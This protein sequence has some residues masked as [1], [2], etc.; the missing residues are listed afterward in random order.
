LDDI[1]PR[2]KNMPNKVHEAVE[3]AVAGQLAGQNLQVVKEWKLKVIQLYETSLVR[4][5]IMVVGTAGCGKTTIFN[6][7]LKSLT[8]IPG[9]MKYTP[10]ILNPKAVTNA[11]LFGELIKS[12]GEWVPG[13][14]A[15]IWK[16]VNNRANKYTS[17]IICDGPVDAIW[18]ESMNTVLDDNRMLTLANAERIP[19][20]DTTKM[21]FEVENLNNASPA[22]VSRAGIIYVSPEDLSWRP[23]IHTWCEDRFIEK[24]QSHP[25]EKT[26]MTEFT[27]KYMIKTRLM[28]ELAT[29]YVYTM[30]TPEV[31]RTTMLLNLLQAVLQYFTEQGISIDRAL[32]EKTFIYALSWSMGGLFETDDRV[33]FHKEI[34]EKAG[35]PLPPITAQ[36]QISEKE[37]IFDF[38]IDPET[39]NWAY[40]APE[41]WTAPK[42]IIFSQ[43]LIPTSDSTRAE[44]IIHKVSQLP[45]ERSMIREEHGLQHSLLVGSPGTAKTSVF[46]MY[47]DKFDG[48]VRSFKRINFSNAT[49]PSNFQAG[50][51]GELTKH[52]ARV[53]RPNGNKEM[54][55]FMDDYSMPKIN[56]WGDQETLEITRLCIEQRGL[57]SLTPDDAG[58]FHKF[59][60]LK[61]CAA[62]RHP[63]GGR[64]TIPSRIMRHFFSMN[65]PPPST[66]AI[67]NIYG[68]ILDAIITTKRYPGTTGQEIIGM[69]PLLIES[70]IVLWETVSKR[71]LPTPTKFH[72]EFN[73]RDLARV[74]QGIARVAQASEYKVI[75]TTSRLKEKIAPTL[76]MIG[77]WRHE[78]ERTFVDRLIT[79]QDKKIFMDMLGK[80]TKEKYRD[81]C[82]FDD[83]QLMTDLLFADFQR[84]AE[85][86]E[87]GSV[88][89]EAP[90]VYEAC[91][92]LSSIKKRVNERLADYNE[93]F[94][95]KKME[96][97]IFDD[98][99]YH[100]LRTTR[101][102]NSANGNALLVGVGGSGKQSLTK[103]SA[104]IC[105]HKFFQ[106]QLTKSYTE[107]S[108]MEDIKI[109]FEEIAMRNGSV[110]FIITDAEIK[111]EG[112]LELINSLLATGEIPGMLNKDDREMFSLGVKPQLQKDLGKG[113]EPTPSQLAAFF[114]QKIKDQLH[115]VLAFS[116]VGNKF[117]TRASYFPSL[118]SQCAIDWFLPWPKEALVDVSGRFIGQFDIECTPEVKEEL[119]NHMGEC[120]NMVQGV[121]DVYF[122]RMRRN[123]YVTPKSYLS[124]IDLYKTLYKAKWQGIDKD[125]SNIQ[126]GLAKLLEA[127]EGV[128][129]MKKLL[130]AED[131]KLRQATEETNKLIAVLTVENEAAEKKTI[132]VQGTKE[133]CIAKKVSIGLEK[134]EADKDLRAAMPFVEAAEKALSGIKDND[135]SE[136]KAMKR[137]HD[138]CRLILDTVQILF[139]GPLVPVSV[140]EY[141]IQKKPVNFITDSY[142][143]FTA[144]LLQGPLRNQLAFF[145]VED[146]NLINEETI[147]L[148]APYLE[149]KFRDVEQEV[150]QG[151]IA[152]G[153]SSALKGVCEWC[154]AMSDYHKASKIVKPK[155]RLLNQKEGE[156][157]VAESQLES[158]QQELAAVIK[159]KAGLDAMYAEKQSIKEAMQAKANQLKR[160]MDQATKLIDSLADNKIRWTQSSQEFQSQ[161]IRLAGDVAKASAFVS[162]CGPFNAE[163]RNLL[164]TEYFENDLNTRKIPNSDDLKLTQFLVDEQTVGDWNMEGLPTDDLSIQNGIMVTRSS[165]YPLMIDP[166]G[167]AITWIRNRERELE[168]F[169]YIFTL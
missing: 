33:K 126:S 36:K 59:E 104:H 107:K 118:F 53:F 101:T 117:R 163:F 95:A 166:Q 16:R 123:V 40:W 140:K 105:K 91:T 1:F 89:A 169:G 136:L 121:R 7:L 55:V 17:W 72:Y 54:L 58:V 92:S 8:A 52:Q 20:S 27:E 116:P 50:I 69:K 10:T 60:Q 122:E 134:E 82:G 4:H 76:F 57:Y 84:D 110:S 18:I 85:I 37:S 75:T 141:A 125:Q 152:K 81:A 100:L 22:T 156:L 128:G 102:I 137:P 65:M 86:D 45:L 77:L 133:A 39:K 74:F 148:L 150:F 135:I 70:T 61:Y 32:Y 21:T 29:K 30:Q 87:Y 165:R 5:G 94:P 96:L 13:I 154:R 42:K 145:G 138:I 31:V 162:Y 146:K 38:Y 80:V 139:L 46:I 149:L 131:V 48:D 3:K 28:R 112:F 64:N 168:Q 78:A 66:R 67:Q 41:V 159:K 143:E 157:R 114:L 99:L 142:E 113:V 124:F 49:R 73:I 119:V 161:K 106:I 164:S 97:V 98:A 132:E 83:D 93:R 35:A 120:H 103:L 11:Q 14:L 147:E 43:L 47:A 23:L 6:V 108:L 68:R 79:N 130:Q 129:E 12:S 2:Q 155:L 34:L 63:T 15:E 151:D 109:L 26:Y 44:Y 167:Q 19:M 62:M 56:D 51:E 160:K 144:S 25:D 127:T 71:L 111:S 24:Y 115:M 9:N 88:I 153:S 90:S 158:A